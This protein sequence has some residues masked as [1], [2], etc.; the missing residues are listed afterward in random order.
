MRALNLFEDFSV[1]IVT[2]E[3]TE[4]EFGHTVWRGAVVG[5]GEATFVIDENQITGVVRAGTRSF[6]IQPERG[7]HRIIEFDRTGVPK[8]RDDAIAPDLATLPPSQETK[9]PAQSSTIDREGA[10]A[11]PAVV[12]LLVVYTSAAAADVESISAAASLA[13]VYT[14]TALS[15]SQ[16][17][18][19]FTLAGIGT[20]DV[21]EASVTMDTILSDFQEGNG[22]FGRIQKLRAN[23]GADL[24]QIWIGENG[25]P[26]NCGLGYLLSDADQPNLDLTSL[27]TFGVSTVT[28]DFG[29]ACLTSTIAHE[30]GHNLG[31]EHDRFQVE[32]DVAGP[33][34]Y[35]YGYVDLGFFRSIMSYDAQ[36]VAENQDCPEIQYYSNPNVM[37]NGRPTGADDATPE[38]A[39]SARKIG[40]IAQVVSQLDTYLTPEPLIQLGLVSSGLQ[41]ESGSFLRVHNTGTEAGTATITLLTEQGDTWGQWTSPSVAP[42]AELQFAVT[43]IESDVASASSKPAYYS[44]GIRTSFQGYTQH[45]LYRPADG[46]LTN[47]STCSAGVT[48]DRAVLSGVHSSLIAAG[49]PSTI[50]INNTGSVATTVSLGIYDAATGNKRGTYVSPSISANGQ[51]VVAV[52]TM[53]ADI[54]MMPTANMYHYVVKAESQFDGFLQHLVNNIQVGV[55]TDMTTACAID[56]STAVAA[57]SPLRLGAVFSTQQTSSQSFLRFHNTGSSD[58][59]I[60]VTARDYVTG[61]SLGQWTST[62]VSPNGESQFDIGTLESELNL[63]M[64]QPDYYSLSIQSSTAGYIQ[65][66]LYRPADGTLTNL[67]TC[68]AG[69]TA[70]ARSLSGVHSSLL[71]SGF[72]SS[73][74]INNTGDAARAAVLT[75]YDARSGAMLGGA[76]TSAD[77]APNGHIS[78]PVSIIEA[79]IGVVPES[80]QYHYVVE[81]DAAFTGFL[82]HLVNNVQAGV[83]TDMTTTC[84]LPS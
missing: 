69:V 42:D 40:E 39:N 64:M 13:V 22:D 83:I 8:N 62:S 27:A 79:A 30:L 4:D 46:T 67:S 12:R 24:V 1:R 45:V 11:T 18:V 58:S 9:S 80:G 43:N 37:F 38:A 48:A 44:V 17:D 49:F 77:V 6:R 65:H 74:V 34:G 5:G 10:A 57:V 78:V 73:I 76:Y 55:I 31:S 21:Q 3:A 84:R 19:Q 71:G 25:S 66:V 61:Q 81:A 52:T 33:E 51:A 60:T 50:V 7:A 70:A 54:G 41:T 68:K 28:T 15:N 72:P 63:S 32:D 26:D 82:Q 47:L 35:N 53:E 23:L 36:C 29:G 59:T 2:L 16:V 75:V 20:V 14:N 56:G